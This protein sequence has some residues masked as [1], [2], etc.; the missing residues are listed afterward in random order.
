MEPIPRQEPSR[1]QGK[2]TLVDNPKSKCA[3]PHPGTETPLKG[4]PHR[5]GIAPSWHRDFQ[6]IPRKSRERLPPIT[7]FLSPITPFL[8]ETSSDLDKENSKLAEI[9]ERHS[10]RRE[11]SRPTPAADTNSF[12]DFATIDWSGVTVFDKQDPFKIDK[13]ECNDPF[14]WKKAMELGQ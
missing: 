4:E 3:F 13:K 8:D 7:P 10:S 1:T 12:L 2:Q 6:L 5:G 11:E 9:M 14:V